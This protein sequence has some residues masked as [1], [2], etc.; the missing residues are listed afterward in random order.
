MQYICTE[1]CCQITSIDNNIV[2][3]LSL[4]L[5]LIDDQFQPLQ[6]PDEGKELNDELLIAKMYAL[7]FSLVQA[8]FLQHKD[9]LFLGSIVGKHCLQHLDETAYFPLTVYTT[10]WNDSV[11][12]YVE[13]EKLDPNFV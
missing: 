13:G 5:K 9:H 12:K 8:N 2:S 1:C 6:S 7:G 11:Q 3:S 10:Q 4:C